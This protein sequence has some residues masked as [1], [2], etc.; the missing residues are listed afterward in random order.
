MGT[1]SSNVSVAGKTST[2]ALFELL[3]ADASCE[4]GFSEVFGCNASINK[5]VASETI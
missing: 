5:V 1:I 2:L 3:P 4:A